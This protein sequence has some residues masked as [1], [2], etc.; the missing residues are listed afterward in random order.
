MKLGDIMK[1]FLLRPWSA[2]SKVRRKHYGLFIHHYV[3][4]VIMLWTYR[5]L[6]QSCKLYLFILF[7]SK[8]LVYGSI[9]VSEVEWAMIR[10]FQ[11][12]RLWMMMCIRN[13][14]FGTRKRCQSPSWCFHNLNACEVVCKPATFSSDHVSMLNSFFV[15]SKL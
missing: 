13:Y 3:D 2:R 12:I 10:N 14:L 4:L 1:Q 7:M 8:L 15:P 5:P 11:N 9:I 6:L